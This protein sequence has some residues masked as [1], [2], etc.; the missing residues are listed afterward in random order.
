MVAGP[1]A[2]GSEAESDKACDLYPVVELEEEEE[3]DEEEEDEEEEEEEGEDGDFIVSEDAEVRD[4]SAEVSEVE[5][6]S[7]DF[8]STFEP[9][10]QLFS[11]VEPQQLLGTAHSFM[12]DTQLTEMVDPSRQVV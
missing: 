4:M 10:L 3:E 2:E 12:S 8:Q 7:I 11:S 5:L 9:E 1:L 6:R